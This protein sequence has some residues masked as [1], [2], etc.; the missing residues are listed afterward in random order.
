M[1]TTARVS[2]LDLGLGVPNTFSL[3]IVIISAAYHYHRLNHQMVTFQWSSTVANSIQTGRK[4]PLQ[5]MDND[6]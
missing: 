6:R 5:L 1:Y 4:N 2:A 3:S